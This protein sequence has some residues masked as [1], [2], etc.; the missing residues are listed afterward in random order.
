MSSLAFAPADFKRA[1]ILQD[2][3]CL[4]C[5]STSSPASKEHVFAAW[6]LSFLNAK[7]VSMGLFRRNTDGS[8]EPHRQAI[9]L[10]SFRLNRLCENCN[11]GWMSRLE[12][13][14]KPLVIAL[15]TGGAKLES[16]DIE[17]RQL[18]ARWA[19]K[20]AIIESHAVGAES[21][22]D[23]ALLQWMRAC[24]NDVPGRFAVAGC[25]SPHLVIGHLQVGVITD[26]LGGKTIA[27]NIVVLALPNLVLTCAFP[28]PD[29]TDLSYRCKC[30]LS[31]YQPLWPDPAS[32]TAM[33]D[34]PPLSQGDDVFGTLEALAEKIELVHPMR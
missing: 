13:R 18:L 24:E 11:N 15:M 19:G 29:L 2:M 12:E 21:P 26:L 7:S 31:V 23:G 3:M 6:L 30:D 27:G 9:A 32:W 8:S 28:I 1:D 16:L 4:A 34:T 14:V 17:Q 5:G 33:S 20:T 10:D 22:V 25:P